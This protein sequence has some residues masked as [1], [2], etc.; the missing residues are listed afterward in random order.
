MLN[1]WASQLNLNTWCK[2]GKILAV[3]NQLKEAEESYQ[4]AITI[5]PNA[6]EVSANCQTLS[7]QFTE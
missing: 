4:Q 6:S 7:E 2:K 3:M 1:K 5:I